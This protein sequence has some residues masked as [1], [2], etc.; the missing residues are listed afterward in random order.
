M[1]VQLES[2]R[3]ILIIR[4]S[5]LGDILLTTPLIRTIKNRFPKIVIDFL[6]KS[7]YQDVLK[8]NPH[9]NKIFLYSNN[10]N[11]AVVEEIENSNNPKYDLIIDLQNNIRS[12]RITSKLKI[13]TVRFKKYSFRKF[14]LVQTKINLMKNLPLIPERYAKTIGVD[15]DKS[16]VEI[17]SDKIPSDKIS[18]L[19]KIVGICPGAKHFTKRYPI[20]YQIQLCKQL[21]E[22]NFNVVLF[23][24]KID[25]EIC[26]EI[27]SK[28]PEVIN[29]Q[30]NDDIL[31]TISDMK[32]CD[33]IICNDSGLMHVASSLDK[34]LIA[35]FGSTVKEF[36]FMPYNYSNSIIVEN[37]NLGCRPCSHIGRRSCPKTHFNCMKKIKPEDI[38]KLIQ[39]IS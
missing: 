20:E 4:L 38:I 19:K 37:E 17:F 18:G 24:G 8:N 15:L 31:Q 23:G 30:N 22:N 33:I 25:E 1:S 7:E 21:V 5:S 35:I 12:R 3:R 34:K 26:S 2:L 29:L 10:Y 28:V 13:R 27:S 36:G 16:G 11:N 14:L 39:E 6:L 9:L 32:L